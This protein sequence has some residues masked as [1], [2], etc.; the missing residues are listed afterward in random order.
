MNRL[1]NRLVCF[2]LLYFQLFN[3]MYTNAVKVEAPLKA[4]E[5]NTTTQSACLDNGDGLINLTDDNENE[6]VLTVPHGQIVSLNLQ[7]NSETQAD[8]Y[9]IS[10]VDFGD[11]EGQIEEI[12]INETTDNEFTATICSTG[13]EE[14]AFTIVAAA[15]KDEEVWATATLEYYPKL[16]FIERRS[17]A[18]ILTDAKIAASPILPTSGTTLPTYPNCTFS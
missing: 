1:I 14:G 7:F 15:Y 5:G 2:V 12:A 8:S 4:C 3:S 16:S 10:A 11:I 18:A 9:I 17:V 13:M 6:P